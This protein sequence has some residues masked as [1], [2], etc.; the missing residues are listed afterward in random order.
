[1]RQN[2][3]GFN[4]IELMTV[5]AI[6][7]YLAFVGLLA[8]WTNRNLDFWLS[9]FSGNEVSVSYLWAFLLSLLAPGL[10]LGNVIC[11]IARFAIG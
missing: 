7:G 9:Y 3:N 6:P 2:K 10:F 1:M 4:L 8:L 5:M 11:E